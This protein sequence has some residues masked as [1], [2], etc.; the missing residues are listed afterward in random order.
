M[1]MLTM[2][3]VY[4]WDLAWSLPQ[5]SDP[6]SMAQRARGNREAP[7]IIFENRK[8]LPWF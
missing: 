2:R 7:Y 8:K 4:V 3:D 5:Y 1:F 6:L